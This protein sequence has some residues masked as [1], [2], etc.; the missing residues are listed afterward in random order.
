LDLNLATKKPENSAPTVS[1]L[2]LPLTDSALVIDLPDGQKIVVGKMTQGSVIEVAT[3]RGVGR[4]DS[5]TSRLML[6]VGSGN[7]D[8]VPSAPDASAS[9]PG[10]RVKPQGWKIVLYYLSIVL[11]KVSSINI[12]KPLGSIKALAG[13]VKLP[14]KSLSKS[15]TNSLSTTEPTQSIAPQSP[16]KSLSTV[17]E[18]VEAW[19]NKISEKASKRSALEAKSPRPAVNKSVT[20]KKAT[21]KQ[22]TSKSKR[23]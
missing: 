8:D 9:N 11:D 21:Q 1:K 12:K 6:G 14:K 10:R 2:P 3:W 7:V 20:V 22:P 18:D 23:K 17:D 13:K 4:P 19:L 5:R 16:M 15:S